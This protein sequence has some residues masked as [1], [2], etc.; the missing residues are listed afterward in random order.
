MQWFANNWTRCNWFASNWFSGQPVSGEQNA[1]GWFGYPGDRWRSRDEDER[2]EAI[3]DAAELALADAAE[4][5]KPALRKITRAEI[6]AARA[7]ADGLSKAEIPF[8]LPSLQGFDVAF[9]FPADQR[10]SEDEAIALVLL[11]S[12][13]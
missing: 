10:L 2:A 6:D 1:G 3:A 13:S 8:S 5:P 7:W 4:P 11:L 9:A 12:E